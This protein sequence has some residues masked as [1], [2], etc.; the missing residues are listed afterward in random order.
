MRNDRVTRHESANSSSSSFEWDSP[1]NEPNEHTHLYNNYD[2]N[3]D[4]NYGYGLDSKTPHSPVSLQA[5]SFLK[6][7]GLNLYAFTYFLIVGTM[8]LLV[9][10]EE[11]VR[12]YP[13]RHALFMGVL[14][15]LT[16]LTQ[17]VSPFA[18]YLSD[19]SSSRF[20]RRRPYMIGGA[21]GACVGLGAMFLSRQLLQPFWYSVA[22]VFAILGMNVSYAAYSALMPDFVPEHQMG[23][24]SG[25]MALLGLVGSCSGFA[26]FS[27]VLD[28]FWSYLV[29]GVLTIT[30]IAV[31][32]L[33]A[34]ERPTSSVHEPIIWR[35]VAR[36]YYIDRSTHSDFFWVF[37]VRTLYYM[38]VS[39]QA[40]I[41]YFVR[42]IS[43]SPNPLAITGIVAM[44]GQASASIIALPAGR[45]SD[46]VG[47]K[48]LV[49]W[50]CLVMGAVYV[51]FLW[52]HSNTWLYILGFV[53]GFGNGLFLPVDYALAC[54]TLPNKKYMA[55]D[56]GVW[57][58]AAFIGSTFGPVLYGPIL[59]SV[60][61]QPG[62]QQSDPTTF[63]YQFTGYAIILG[64]ATTF[65]VSA[66]MLVSLIKG[67]R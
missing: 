43:R 5:L 51:S 25:M 36:C 66:G 57:G 3:Y 30:T 28:V 4:N 65:L 44:L 46:N 47:R 22:L 59:W 54:N 48:P 17:L 9:L 37:I 16:G 38:G 33:A 62:F 42:D 49:R 10:P 13:H 32:C 61:P 18:G 15:G 6:L 55:R 64:L 50:A 27:F 11:A 29:Y 60:G 56:L 67:V 1:P 23:Q 24:A 41:L 19:R 31:T 39:C 53:Y 2:N 52:L 35:E 26:L 40:F 21:L 63:H 8:G 45:M 12:L 58:I 34:N 7:F 20:G 14:L